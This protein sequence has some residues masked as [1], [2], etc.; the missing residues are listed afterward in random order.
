MSQAG[1][2]VQQQQILW[3]I[4]RRKEK[5]LRFFAERFPEI[6]PSIADHQLNKLCLKFD[7]ERDEIDL[8]DGARSIYNGQ[9]KKN[10]SREVESFCNLYHQG[11]YIQSIPNFR[12]NAFPVER[13]FYLKM[14][15]VLDFDAL[16][17]CNELGYQL[18]N[19]YPLVVFMGVGLGF[20]IE[21]LLERCNVHHVLIF[22][23]DIEQLSAS[24]MCVDWEKISS[25]HQNS[26]GKSLKIV[27]GQADSK[28][29]LFN[30]IWDKLTYYIP[31]FPTTTLFF[32]HLGDN[33]RREMIER[34]NGDIL[35]VS[36]SYGCYDDEI[37]QI[38]NTLHNLRR[39]AKHA[40]VFKQKIRSNV[41]IV[42]AGPSLTEKIEDLRRLQPYA[43][44]ISCGTAL[45]ILHQ[46]NL[47]PDIHIEIESNHDTKNAINYLNDPEWVRSIKFICMF[48][49][50]PYV[51]QLFDDTR[52]ILNEF[53]TVGLIF[54]G[55]TAHLKFS[56]PT[57]VNGAVSLAAYYHPKAI[58]LFGCDFGFRDGEHHHAVGTMYDKV[59]V[60]DNFKRDAEALSKSIFY[61]TAVD[62]SP[63]HTQINMYKGKKAIEWLIATPEYRD[64]HFYN[65]SNGVE[66]TGAEWL[67]SNQQYID[68]IEGDNESKANLLSDY[69]FR[70]PER[71]IECSAGAIDIVLRRVEQGLAELVQKVV[72]EVKLKLSSLSDV[73]EMCSRINNIFIN[74]KTTGG[75]T[76]ELLLL[77]GSMYHFL[78]VLYGYCFMQQDQTPIKSYYKVWRDNFLDFLNGV[79]GHYRSVVFR[80]ISLEQDGRVMREAFESELPNMKHIK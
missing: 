19:F 53:S 67:T 33:D 40:P 29:E 26:P 41:I 6:Y 71:T 16:D 24:L 43:T 45:G 59:G 61:T 48:Q 65:C 27:L 74:I 21:Q 78:H 36:A 32:N 80:N 37:N 14:N 28:D 15:K 42:G 47:K 44:I 22:E 62:G 20:Q 55:L 57:V 54:G 50:N 23:S 34:V 72:P 7:P 12:R 63:I 11:S 66:I 13:Y 76:A 70:D 46:H 58:C 17:K 35:Q 10:A 4:S 56:G 52:F 68:L 5:N 75:Y 79:V 73:S 3:E 77:Q 51:Y 8:F 49:T 2:Q 9:A 60:A 69:I 18:G 25:H 31:Q 1:Y 39:K 64:I 38:N 30:L